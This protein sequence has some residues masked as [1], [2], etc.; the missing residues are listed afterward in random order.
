[1]FVMSEV[2][3]YSFG[4]Q[5]RKD[6]GLF[7]W[8]YDRYKWKIRRTLR[9]VIWGWGGGGAAPW[10]APAWRGRGGGEERARERGDCSTNSG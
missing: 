6:I 8:W 5:Y 2:P 4:R 7:L 10:N 3:L 1:M 9:W